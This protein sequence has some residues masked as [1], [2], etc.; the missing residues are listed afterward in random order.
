VRQAPPRVDP[1]RGLAVTSGN[2]NTGLVTRFVAVLIILVLGAL[3]SRRH[4]RGRTK[5]PSPAGRTSTAS[6]PNHTVDANIAYRLGE[7]PTARTDPDHWQN[8]KQNHWGVLKVWHHR[9]SAGSV[10]TVGISERGMGAESC[11]TRGERGRRRSTRANPQNVMFAK[12][13]KRR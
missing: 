9:D 4:T 2:Q 5:H 6:T 10:T 8:T 12:G 7:A 11:A 13:R 1:N 3:A